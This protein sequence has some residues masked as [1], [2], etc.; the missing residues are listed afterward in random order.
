MK[1]MNKLLYVYLYNTLSE[2]MTM[3]D[4]RPFRKWHSYCDV[5]RLEIEAEQI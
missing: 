1:N 2:G 3:K 4:E 5:T